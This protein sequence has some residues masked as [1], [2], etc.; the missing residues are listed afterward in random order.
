MKR[1]NKENGDSPKVIKTYYKDIGRKLYG[2]GTGPDKL[3]KP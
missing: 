3:P 1:K 2:S